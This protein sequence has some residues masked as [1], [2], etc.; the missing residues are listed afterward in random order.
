MKLHA[1]LILTTLLACSAS[2]FAQTI[3]IHVTKRRR[4]WYARQL[5][6]GTSSQKN[7]E[8]MYVE[9]RDVS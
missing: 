4:K 7:L 6:R 5:S 3:G 8:A 9:P 2:A 1:A